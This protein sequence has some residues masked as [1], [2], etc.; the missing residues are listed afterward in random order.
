MFVGH[1]A[2]GFAAKR[3]DPAPSL[4]TYFLAAQLPDV[5]WP[6]LL[7]AGVERAAIAPGDTVVTPLRFEH[8]PVSHSLAAVALWGLAFGGVHFARRRRALAAATLAALAVSHWLLDFASHRPDLPILPG[9]GPR[10][11]LGLWGSLPATLAVEGAL[12]GCGVWLYAASTRARD[13]AGKYGF[14]GLAGLLA[15]LYLGN[16]FGPPPPSVEAVGAVSL[17]GVVGIWLLASWV[18]RHREP[19]VGA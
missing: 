7:L 9:D 13:R 5:V 17:L 12:Y 11:G 8:Y 15:A 2:M 10:Y 3:L 1:F 18:D 14:A 4:G 19:A 6:V 16:L